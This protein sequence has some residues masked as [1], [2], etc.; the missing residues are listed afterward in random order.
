MRICTYLYSE[1]GLGRRVG[2]RVWVAR[3]I[4]ASER[5]TGVSVIG[6]LRI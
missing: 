2:V 3:E 1:E 4:R 6:L 5:G